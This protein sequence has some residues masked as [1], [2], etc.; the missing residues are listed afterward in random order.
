MVRRK[1]RPGAGEVGV[2]GVDLGEGGR[3]VVGRVEEIG[4]A[5]RGGDEFEPSST[6]SDGWD[7]ATAAAG[8]AALR[9]RNGDRMYGVKCERPV[10][11]LCT[12]SSRG[13]GS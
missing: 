1:G 5:D 12:S 2:L 7:L 9:T 10:T 3:W 6:G 4:E 8:W 13:R 11:K